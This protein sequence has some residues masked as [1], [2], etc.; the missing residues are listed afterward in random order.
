MRRTPLFVL[1]FLL[2]SPLALAQMELKEGE[3]LQ[4]TVEIPKGTN[5]INLDPE[6]F[7]CNQG[8]ESVEIKSYSFWGRGLDLFVLPE[9]KV[10]N[11]KVFLNLDGK[12]T[13]YEREVNLQNS[14][15]KERIEEEPFSGGPGVTGNLISNSSSPIFGFGLLGL[16]LLSSF[17][18]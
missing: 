18:S 10:G 12:R 13:L 1:V 9:K 5:P 3:N 4:I 17:Q 7:I 6:V 15:K 2:F 16:V 11:L 8:C 14:Y